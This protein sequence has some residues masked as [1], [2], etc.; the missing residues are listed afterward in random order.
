[1]DTPSREG[2]SNPTSSTAESKDSSTN[3]P[4]EANAISSS[5]EKPKEA[6][7]HDQSWRVY[8]DY[9]NSMYNTSSS[10]VAV[11][12]DRKGSVPGSSDSGYKSGDDKKHAIGLNGLIWEEH[13]KTMEAAVEERR[14][15]DAFSI[16]QLKT[17]LTR[18]EGDA[19]E[20]EGRVE[21]LEQNILKLMLDLQQEQVSSAKKD[22][23]LSLL[24]KE[25]EEKKEILAKKAYRVVELEVHAVLVEDHAIQLFEELR[26]EREKPKDA[27]QL[28]EQVTQLKKEAIQLEVNAFQYLQELQDEQNKSIKKEGE[29]DQDYVI[30]QQKHDKLQ[31]RHDMYKKVY[32]GALKSTD[33]LKDQVKLNEASITSLQK[34]NS[35]LKNDLMAKDVQIAGLKASIQELQNR[36]VFQKADSPEAN[37]SE[38]AELRARIQVFENTAPQGL[39]RLK[40]NKISRLEQDVKQLHEKQL[41][42]ETSE[43]AMLHAGLLRL[44]AE[45]KEKLRLG[46]SKLRAS[47]ESEVEAK[48]KYAQLKKF[49][50]HALHDTLESAEECKTRAS[51]FLEVAETTSVFDASA[52][53]YLEFF[54]SGLGNFGKTLTDAF[55]LLMDKNEEMANNV[56]PLIKGFVFRIDCLTKENRWLRDDSAYTKNMNELLRKDNAKYKANEENNTFLLALKAEK[57]RLQDFCRWLVAQHIEDGE[58]LRANEFYED[59]LQLQENVDHLLEEIRRVREDFWNLNIAAEQYRELY[60]NLATQWNALFTQAPPPSDGIQ[61]TAAQDVATQADGQNQ[62]SYPPPGQDMSSDQY[63]NGHVHDDGN[64]QRSNPDLSNAQTQDYSSFDGPTAQ[65]LYEQLSNFPSDQNEVYP[66]D[67]NDE[68]SE[69]GTEEGDSE[70]EGFEKETFQE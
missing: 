13:S 2:D 50:E 54:V 5:N 43:T 1:M 31:I 40:D 46:A 6:T 12:E 70:E 60:E 24:Q 59:N 3:S 17:Q 58:L 19:V 61:P 57:D 36:P 37:G 20:R 51:E 42:A 29:H 62:Q 65:E 45:Q 9:E 16:V 69:G 8:M 34:D 21:F 38:I 32:E 56:A 26:Q 15:E 63:P 52:S 30:W 66:I 33:S 22:E 11:S 18:L 64:G 23:H 49:I 4:K 41:H 55:E 35:Q 10:M 44:L 7:Q 28:E 48:L 53:A 67:E 27:A 39:I 68:L 25:F 47:I 14:K